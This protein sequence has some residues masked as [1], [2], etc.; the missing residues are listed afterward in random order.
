[1]KFL[2]LLVPFLTAGF[3]VFSGGDAGFFPEFA[4]EIVGGGETAAAGDL[5]DGQFI[6]H[7]QVDGG[8][9][10]VACQLLGGSFAEG[11]G[12]QFVKIGGMQAT[13]MGKGLQ[14]DVFLQM[15]P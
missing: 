9:N 1:M 3:A 11:R 12:K 7:Q 13:V 2:L 14:T 6:V 8:M 4:T 5:A 15:L 10:A